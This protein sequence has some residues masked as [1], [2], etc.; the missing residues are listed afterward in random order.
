MQRKLLVFES[1][2]AKNGKKFKQ[3]ATCHHSFFQNGPFYIAEW[4]ILLVKM[5]HSESQNGP[6]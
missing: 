3:K 1:K 5:N 4:L 6:F 2:Q